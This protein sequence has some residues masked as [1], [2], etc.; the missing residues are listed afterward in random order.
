MLGLGNSDIVEQIGA[1]V[2]VFLRSM[3][4]ELIRRE[5]TSQRLVNTQTQLCF[6][7]SK[8]LSLELGRIK[9]RH[10]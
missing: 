5:V 1:E 3:L 6:L 4:Q 10:A 9:L 8:Q 7:I 2:D